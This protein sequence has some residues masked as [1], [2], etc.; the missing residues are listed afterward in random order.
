VVDGTASTTDVGTER[1][2]RWAELFARLTDGGVGVVRAD[3]GSTELGLL[4]TALLYTSNGGDGPASPPQLVPAEVERRIAESLDEGGFPPTDTLGLLCRHRLLGSRSAVIATEQQVV[5]FNLGDPLGGSCPSRTDEP[6]RLIALY[7]SD[8]RSLDHQFVAFSW[9][10]PPQEQ[11]AAGFG[12][13]LRT[14]PGR[15]AIAAAGLRPVG[16]YPVGAALTTGGIDPGALPAAEPIPAEQWDATTAAYDAAQRR[17]RVLFALDTSGSMAADGPE[18][19]RSAVA[20]AAVSAAL[21]GMGPRDQFGLWFFPDAAG[22]GPVEAMPLGPREDARL[23]A[24][25]QLLAG[26][27]PA[28]NTPL[29]R[30]MIDAAEALNPDDP[31]QVD[32]VV[33]LTDGEDTSS[34]LGPDAVSA[35]LADSGVRLI[36]VTIGEIRCSDAGLAAV[37]TVTAGECVDADLASLDTTLRT[38]M[39]GLWGGR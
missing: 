7:P 29:F 23:A 17:G 4:A 24:A 32:A 30:T 25:R 38:A 10:E 12:D 22:T 37:T 21:E 28:G 34:G 6:G 11:A 1:G 33:V 35:A 19:Q 5:R 13:W 26:A 9:S 18:G 3:P 20:T 39:A 14:D 15:G 27:L 31:A 16:P 2:G 36:V 8:S